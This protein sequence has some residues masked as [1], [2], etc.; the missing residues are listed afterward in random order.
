MASSTPISSQ[1]CPN[2]LQLP[3]H[4]P[5][6][7]L[8]LAGISLS[9]SKYDFSG[10]LLLLQQQRSWDP[11]RPVTAKEVGIK[12][13]AEPRE[14]RDSAGEAVLN[15]DGDDGVPDDVTVEEVI[16]Q[17]FSNGSA[18][19]QRILASGDSLSLGIREPVYE[20]IYRTSFFF[21]IL[22]FEFASCLI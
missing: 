6:F 14:E 13:F 16:D 22:V 3:L 2:V 19:S 8:I 17:D 21:G 20:V 15:K 9:R 10:K 5:Q 4:S 18:G 12:C 11:L 7:R 1:Y